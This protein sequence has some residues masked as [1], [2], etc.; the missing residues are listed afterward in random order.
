MSNKVKKPLTKHKSFTMISRRLIMRRLNEELRLP[1]L[2]QFPE[3]DVMDLSEPWIDRPIT[4]DILN[5]V[6]SRF[7]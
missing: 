5:E 3:G 2:M 1:A 7:Q 4:S 6:I